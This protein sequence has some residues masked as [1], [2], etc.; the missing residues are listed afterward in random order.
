MQ[1]FGFNMWFKLFYFGAFSLYN[2]V[3]CN[4]RV[5]I[6]TNEERD[7]RKMWQKKLVRYV[8]FFPILQSVH[9]LPI[10]QK[11]QV[12]MCVIVYK[13]IYMSSSLI[14]FIVFPKYIQ[15][16]THL[17]CFFRC[18]RKELSR[19]GMRRIATDGWSRWKGF[20]GLQSGCQSYCWWF[21]HRQLISC[22]STTL[23]NSPEL[24]ILTVT[25]THLL[26][27]SFISVLL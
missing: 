1:V 5:E 7:I 2:D 17:L 16:L 8:T 11:I 10:K 23:N 25:F 13:V 15:H 21:R 18:E 26:D 4:F 22:R 27:Q 24:L 19:R 14:V 9:W 20:V 3:M 6:F 12:K